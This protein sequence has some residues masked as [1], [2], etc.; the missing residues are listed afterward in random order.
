MDRKV[1]P[2]R[3]AHV[4]QAID[5]DLIALQEVL[6]IDDDEHQS[7]QASYLAK[8]L[9]MHCALGENRRLLGGAYGNVTLSRWPIVHVENYDLTIRTAERRGC[10]RTD[11][12]LPTGERLHLFNVHL[13]TSFLERRH[14]GRRL[15]DRALLN[16][17]DLT[18][19]RLLMGDFN[20]WTHGLAS[21]LL[22][23]HLESADIRVHLRRAR[24]Y[25]ALMPVWHLDHV[26]HDAA[27]RIE[28]MSLCQSR[29]AYLASDHLPLIAELLPDR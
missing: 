23:A 5:A 7:H 16:H 17:P 10:L 11:V 13:G 15:V 1:R 3:I 28:R 4:L 22:S 25:P 2:D 8:A 27:L 26:Y 14:Q 24:T 18:G 29:L 12:A 20:E 19:P 6:S 9:G 21:Q